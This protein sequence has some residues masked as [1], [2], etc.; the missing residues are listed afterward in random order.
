MIKPSK[1]FFIR[2]APVKI[3]N[4]FFPRNNP[5][6]II[7]NN[8]LKKLA[9]LIPKN[10]V[11]YVSPLKRTI[12]TAKALAEYVPYSKM[13]KEKKLVEQNYGDWEGKKVSEIW[14]I[15]ETKKSKHNFS[16][17]S[18]DICPPNGESFL[19]QC[20]RVS[21]WLENLNLLEGEN[22]VIITHAGTIRAALSHTLGINPDNAVGIEI[23]HQTISV[24]E[25]ISKKN[26]QHKGGR[27]RFLA[28]NK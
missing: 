9:T 3:I 7:K 26:N 28:L 21:F 6:A 14:K 12:Q 16:F 11:W 25:M 4:G 19:E 15:L 5:N 10:C 20:T 22:V 18:P 27:Y 8:K 13:I 17:I 1:L 23:L 2:H 24:F